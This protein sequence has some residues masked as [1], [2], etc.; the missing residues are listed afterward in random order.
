MKITH[1]KSVPNNVPDDSEDILD[2]AVDNPNLRY[3]HSLIGE[4]E[5][6]LKEAGI[7]DVTFNTD[8]ETLYVYVS[9]EAN[10]LNVIEYAVPFD[11]LQ[12]NWDDMSTDVDYILDAITGNSTD[13]VESSTD[14]ENVDIQS[15][16]KYLFE[17]LQDYGASRIAN[18]IDTIKIYFNSDKAVSDPTL[19]S[20]AIQTLGYREVADYGE[21]PY[22]IDYVNDA[23]TVCVKLLW[24]ADDAIVIEV[25]AEQSVT[26]ATNTSNIGVAPDII[27]AEDD[28]D[29][30]D[31]DEDPQFTEIASKRVTNSQGIKTDYTM[32][33]DIETGEYVFVLGDKDIVLPSEDTLDWSCR[34]ESEAWEWYNDYASHESKATGKTWED[35]IIS[36]ESDL[37]YEVD[38]A[39][40]SQPDQWI[41]M[42]KG[43]KTYEG[44]VT[45][46]FEGDYELVAENIHETF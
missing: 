15:A 1:I 37:G 14:I 18:F 6:A 44:E 13:V 43:D 45:R 23:N 7:V 35:F 22:V 9:I 19:T 36:I 4:L 16:A 38:S 2:Y 24:Y 12:F 31:D 33:R 46:Y 8:S 40:K 29:Y 20:A 10:D 39:Y 11:D 30:L 25:S 32:Y 17:T 41:I 34:Y 26:S 28:F 27:T 21:D 5:P 3:I 42:Y